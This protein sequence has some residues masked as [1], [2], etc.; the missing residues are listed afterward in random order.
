MEKTADRLNVMIA[1]G[2]TGGH[3]FP[4][5]A[6]ALELLKKHP[7]LKITFI[8]AGLKH[9]DYF[10]KELFSYL[11]IKSSTPFKKGPLKILKAL[12]KLTQ[13]TLRSLNF[14]SR[15][16]PDVIVGV[17]KLSYVSCNLSSAFAQSSDCDL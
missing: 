7:E 1:A 3:L 15:K 9:N 2:G 14:F 11:D 6:L 17:W 8:G 16:K 4:A 13:G 10:K 12:I 5:Q